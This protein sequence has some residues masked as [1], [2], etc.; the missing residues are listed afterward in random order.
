M[1]FKQSRCLNETFPSAPRLISIHAPAKSLLPDQ[2]YIIRNL[3]TAALCRTYVSFLS[4]SAISLTTT[5]GKPKRGDAVRVNDRFQIED[6]AFVE[7]LWRETGLKEI[8][9][10]G[11]EDEDLR[12]RIEDEDLRD[13]I[14][15][16]D[17]RDGIEDEDLRDN[18]NIWGGEVLGLNPNVRIYRYSPGQFFAQHC[19]PRFHILRS[20]YLSGMFSDLFADDDSNSLRFPSSSSSPFIPGKTTWTLLIY[21]TTCEGGETVFYPDPPPPPAK[22]K[23]AAVASSSQT[24]GPIVVGMEAGM[25]LLHRHGDRCL[26]HE[27]RKVKAGEKWVIRSD[28]VVRR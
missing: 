19:K 11:I 26:L 6:R 24:D 15:D 12:D 9:E 3:L 8:V 27:A 17:L 23:K 20:Q 22:S 13:R 16:E 5:P 10:R 4:S 2:I 28:L 1:S 21:L 14:E 7:R 18:N 25:A